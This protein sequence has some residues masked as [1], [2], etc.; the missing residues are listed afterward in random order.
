MNKIVLLFAV[1]LFSCLLFQCSVK[2]ENEL[3]CKDCEE[4]PCEEHEYELSEDVKLYREQDKLNMEKYFNSSCFPDV[5]DKYVYPVKHGTEEW[6]KY[7]PRNICTG[8]TPIEKFC[9]LPDS[10]LNSISTL[11]LIRSF[12][13]APCKIYLEYLLSSNGSSL[14][15]ARRLFPKFNSL[16]ELLTREDAAKLLIG[17][18]AAIMLD[19]YETLDDIGSNWEFTY[20]LRTFQYLFTM[21]EI[22]NQFDN[23]DKVNAVKSLLVTNKQW[24]NMGYVNSGMNSTILVVMV[25]IMYDDMLPFFDKETLENFKYEHYPKDLIDDIIAFAENFIQ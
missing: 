1:I 5:E 18:N 19:C 23:E 21:P 7:N 20:R 14:H 4:K 24:V 15:T 10:V 11:R 12:V 3:P 8:E 13:D 16:Q 25:Y 9:Q 17:Y 6:W 2:H 22:L